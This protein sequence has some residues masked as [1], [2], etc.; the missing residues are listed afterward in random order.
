MNLN[1]T[2]IAVIG[3]LGGTFIGGLFTAVATLI[4]KQSEEKRHFR[5][6]VV[7]TASEHWS[8]VAQLPTT[9]S[10]PPLTDY[11]VHTVKMCD[12]VFNK[13]LTS[14][15][16]KPKLEEISALMDVLHEHAKSNAANPNP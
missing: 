14:K 7:K 2:E 15:N 4:N 3:T 11:I 16:V 9:K 10:I 1:P 13:E 5:E 8:R 12:L 6:L